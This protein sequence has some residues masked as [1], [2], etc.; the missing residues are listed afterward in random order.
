[1]RTERLDRLR[2]AACAAFSVSRLGQDRDRAVHADFEHFAGRCQLAVLAVMTKVWPVT[3]YIRFDFLSGFRMGADDARQA[4][5]L[6]RPFEIEIVE[7]LGNARPL[8]VLALAQLDVWPEPARLAFDR[9]AGFRIFAQHRVLA[10]VF[11]FAAGL[12]ELARELAFGIVGTG[13]ESAIATTAQGEPAAVASFRFAQRAMARIL[14]VGAFGEK[15]IGEE[16]V[17]HLGH[18]GRLL[19]HDLFGLGLEIAPEG[20]EQL[21]PVLAPVGHGIELFLEPGRVIERNILREEPFQKRCQQAAR[22][23]CK[24]TIFL[25]PDVIA[26]ADGLDRAG[27]GRRTPDAELF[28]LLDQARL[29][30]AGR[31]LG[32]MLVRLDR[33]LG[34]GIALV[35]H[36]QQA[37]LV[38]VLVVE[39]FLVD[40]EIARE[41]HHLAGRAQLVLAGSVTQGDGGAFELRGGHLARHRAFEDQ[42]VKLALVARPR[43]VAAEIGRTNRLV[44]FLRVLGLGRIEPRL[45]GQV[46]GIVAIGDGL[47]AGVDGAAVHL[48]TVGTHVSD[49]TRL[50]ERLGEPHRMAG[51]KAQLAGGFLLQ[52]RSGEW[53]RGIALQ[54]L[55]FDVLDRETRILDR[56]LRGHGAAFIA[57]RQLVELLPVEL[58]QP[59]VELRPVLLKLGNDRPVFV[60]PEMLD[61]DFAVDDDAQRHRLHAARALRAGKAAPEDRRKGETV[62][63][64]QCSAR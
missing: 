7:V 47:A 51:R 35:H 25:H 59:G 39:A 11:A 36:R 15:V 8:G 62:E 50:V 42:V 31:R 20:L 48:H 53:R 54:W 57:E 41:L 28:Q 32:E 46:I 16:V 29:G 17:E 14:A 38:V 43:A 44:G 33:L 64:V 5:Q 1:M 4:E 61:L 23:L 21:L 10:A 55:R 2:L 9:Q 30:I 34:R 19:V 58:D 56:L 60:G 6:E 3:S 49:R 63:I 37:V 26:V 27:I 12:G 45:V 24:E 40:R 22:F 52:R 13:D 18:F